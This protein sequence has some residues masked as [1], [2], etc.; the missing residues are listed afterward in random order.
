MEPATSKWHAAH[1]AFEAARARELER[2][3]RTGY[4]DGWWD[5]PYY[6][7]H[8]LKQE[9]ATDDPEGDLMADM[10]ADPD[11][12]HHFPTLK[13]MRDYARLR[14]RGDPLVMAAVPSVWRRY[15]KWGRRLGPCLF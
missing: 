9:I 8:W 11:L 3:E 4:C 10:R 1:A 15:R 13:R 5:A 2:R 6:V 12:P 7:Q 14:S